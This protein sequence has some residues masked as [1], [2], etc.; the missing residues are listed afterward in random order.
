M[1][2]QELIPYLKNEQLLLRLYELKGINP[3]SE[4]ILIYFKN[5][6]SLEN[7]ITLFEIEKTDD[8]IEY[9]GNNE[10]F[11]QLMPITLATELIYKDFASLTDNLEIATRLINYAI[12]DA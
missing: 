11:I 8:N 4:A 6:L 10:K 3:E 7:E 1:T 5:Y 2:L 9:V 12:Y